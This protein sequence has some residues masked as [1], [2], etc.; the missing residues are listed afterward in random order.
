MI[1]E[2]HLRRLD[3]I[4]RGRRVRENRRRDRRL[5]RS[6]YHRD[7]ARETKRAKLGRRGQFGLRRVLRSREAVKMRG[8]REL[9]ENN[10]RGRENGQRRTARRSFG[11]DVG[12]QAPK[13]LAQSV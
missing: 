6:R 8:S 9:N 13:P 2:R 4:N 3:R 5:R 11:L 7:V 12:I 10:Q 1:F